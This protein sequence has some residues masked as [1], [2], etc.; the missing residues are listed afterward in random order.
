MK[1][2]LFIL[3][4]LA[5]LMYIMKVKSDVIYRESISKIM[6]TIEDLQKFC[7][8]RKNDFCSKEQM[9]MTYFILEEKMDHIRREYEREQEKVRKEEQM[10]K[11]VRKNERKLRE[12]LRQHFLDRYF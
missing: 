1:P 4:V 6:K 9:K 3:L 2:S 10:R 12:K 5:L 11:N 8:H 7:I